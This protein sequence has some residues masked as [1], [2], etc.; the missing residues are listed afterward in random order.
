[1]QYKTK[2][3]V[4]ASTLISLHF[5]VVDFEIEYAG[6]RPNNYTFFL[7]DDS[8]RLQDAISKITNKMVVVEPYLFHSNMRMLK[9]QCRNFQERHNG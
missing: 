1:M 2:D 8:P 9:S 3:M 6:S 7:F 5:P 4:L